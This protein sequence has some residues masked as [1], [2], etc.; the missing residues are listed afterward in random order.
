MESRLLWQI[1][2]FIRPAVCSQ[3]PSSP[4]TALE[5]TRARPCVRGIVLAAAAAPTRP[6]PFPMAA[7]LLSRHRR[8]TRLRC[9]RKMTPGQNGG[10]EQL[11]LL[12]ECIQLAAS[13]P[14]CSQAIWG[15]GGSQAQA[16]PFRCCSGSLFA[17]AAPKPGAAGSS[18]WR[19]HGW[20]S[21]PAW[22]CG[23]ARERLP[24]PLPLQPAME[25]PW[26]ETTGI[27]RS[28]RSFD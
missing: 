20:Y 7:W 14:P 19:C 15:K 18:A 5:R 12:G 9:D 27:L 21:A 8:V 4:G 24:A 22:V 26:L 17:G 28:V 16:E 23:A 2:C 25:H 13:S 1:R 3:Q 6:Q 10:W 11:P